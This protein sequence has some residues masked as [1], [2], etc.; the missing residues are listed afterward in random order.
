MNRT[1]LRYAVIITQFECDEC[2]VTREYMHTD[3]GAW[4][5]RVLSAWKSKRVWWNPWKS[6]DVC[7]P[8]VLA[9]RYPQR[10]EWQA[11]E[12][13]LLLGNEVSA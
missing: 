2:G 9:K 8:C 13:R 7:P 5:T 11:A 1:T 3:K 4:S 10:N 6:R 12:A